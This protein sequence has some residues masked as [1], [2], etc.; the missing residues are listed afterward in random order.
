VNQPKTNS[1]V[2]TDKRQ[3]EFEAYAALI[4]AFRAQG[5]LS[6]KK[7]TILQDLRTILKISDER[8]KMEIKRADETLGH[9]N[10]RKHRPITEE[11]PSS[12]VADGSSS[13]F[14]SNTDDEKQK[15]KKRHRSEKDNLQLTAL[16][17]PASDNKPA[18][19]HKL[20]PKAAK[21][22]KMK[23][24]SENSTL[25]LVPDTLQEGPINSSIVAKPPLPNTSH[26][27]EFSLNEI[28]QAKETGNL[29]VL[30]TAVSTL[31]QKK[32]KVQEQLSNFPSIIQ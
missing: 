19:V 1:K 7:E 32:E 17:L 27:M 2:E 26:E 30:K 10:S 22:K 11:I 28:T 20:P 4:S 31:L 12:P 29:I 13:E 25:F 15:T 8:H 16:P 3:L 21:S 23:S 18:F 6:W 14:E 9:L 5:E 24:I